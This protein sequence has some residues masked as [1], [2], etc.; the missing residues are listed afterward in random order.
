MLQRQLSPISEFIGSTSIDLASANRIRSENLNEI[1]A[2]VMLDRAI[3]FEAAG[4]YEAAVDAYRATLKTLPTYPKANARLGSFLH[5][6][7]E[8]S[9]YLGS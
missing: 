1:P 9:S 5:S 3:E 7:G 8:I 6:L 2:R 4:N